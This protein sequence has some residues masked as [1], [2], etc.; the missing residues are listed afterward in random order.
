MP[1]AAQ[2][3][4]VIKLAALG[5]F[6]Q[7]LG[8]LAAIRRHHSDA[9]ITLLTTA[10]FR[11]LAQ[12]SGYVDEVWCDGRPSI[13]AVSEW[14]ALRSRL[15]SGGFDR[16]YD[17]QTSDR[18]SHYFRLFWPG[19]APEWS[20]IAR[21]CSHPHTNPARD[22]M[23]TTER[24]REQL[25]MAGIED[26]PVADV[27]WAEANVTRFDLAEKF[28]LIVPGGALHRPAKRWPVE[29]FAALAV[30]L[31]DRG[32][33]PVLLGGE[34]EAGTFAPIMAA[35]PEAV[36]LA[37]QTDL[38]DLAELGRRAALAVGNDTGPM[39]MIAATG[40]KSLVLYSDASDPALC[41]QRGERVAILHREYLE[42]LKVDEVERDL[43]N[44]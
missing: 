19:P 30:R 2:S 17:L 29:N 1:A 11:A 26:V 7:A 38:F 20:G 8:P 35:C 44:S 9:K 22:L 43:D 14:L 25:A 18:S 40:C 6:I 24:Q 3:I 33:Q 5:D 10:P 41:A 13:L 12:A 21:G 16:V 23:H 4:L 28:A 31:S 27:S 42:D 15:R 39:H 36:Y 32:L 37:G 34:G